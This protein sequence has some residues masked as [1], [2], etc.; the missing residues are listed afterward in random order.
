MLP[1]RAWSG[2]GGRVR[3]PCQH[4]GSDI[5]ENNP[6]HVA[7]TPRAR[8]DTADTPHASRWLSRSVLCYVMLC[9]ACESG[10]LQRPAAVDVGRVHVGRVDVHGSGRHLW[11]TGV[12]AGFRVEGGGYI[13]GSR[14]DR[15]RGG[16]QGTIG[17]PS[18]DSSAHPRC[19]CVALSVAPS[20]DRPLPGGEI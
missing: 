16:N 4:N 7:D 10:V 9:V 20:A 19:P 18:G 8:G 13:R 6:R 5:P 14:V 17:A 3:L 1:V 15:G 2:R 11:K 12:G